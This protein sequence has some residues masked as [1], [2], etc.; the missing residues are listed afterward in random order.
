MYSQVPEQLPEF[1]IFCIQSLYLIIVFHKINFV[2]TIIPCFYNTNFHFLLWWT[3]SANEMYVRVVWNSILEHYCSCPTG[4]IQISRPS[5]VCREIPA[6]LHDCSIARCAM[7]RRRRPMLASPKR[8]C[9]WVHIDWAPAWLWLRYYWNLKT[10]PLIKLH[11]Q[12]Y[13][14]S[15]LT[16][17]K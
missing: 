15:E 2:F 6:W 1:V 4:P 17:L 10:Y 16:Y 9:R 7:L 5:A 11:D 8:I 14:L 13:F 3:V 12:S